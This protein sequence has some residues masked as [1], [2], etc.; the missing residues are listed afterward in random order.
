MNHSNFTPIKNTVLIAQ[1]PQEFYPRTLLN[2]SNQ[3][4]IGPDVSR[5]NRSTSPFSSALYLDHHLKDG[6]RLNEKLESLNFKP[7]I[8]FIKADATRRVNISNLSKLPGW[9][10]LLMGDTHHMKNPLK[11]M[12]S[13]AMSEPFD[14]ISSEH[15]RHHL[16]LFR[17][18]GLKNLIWLPCFTMNPYKIEP[19]KSVQNSAVFVGS[20]SD[21]HYHRRKL[22]GQLRDAQIPLHVT[23][24]SQKQAS[25]LYNSSAVSLNVSLNAD[26][27]FRIMEILAAGG[28]L[29]TDRLGL[30]SGLDLLLT[31]DVHYVA[32]SSF[33]E[34]A[35]KIKWLINEPDT[36]Q[37]IAR[38]G[39]EHF[40]KTFSPSVQSSALLDL[41]EGNPIPSLFKAPD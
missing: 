4:F 12:I 35:S 11:T 23:A 25:L 39:H 3:L 27:N 5:E 31:E 15:D 40:W 29:L 9:K 24:A 22:I 28:C 14:L 20:L 32:Y 33:S 13:Y 1:A 18:A 30:E 6:Y 36:R 19:S 41:L 38:A 7:D 16:S 2:G 10:I 37:A 26:L 8:V 21:H 34:A 17:E